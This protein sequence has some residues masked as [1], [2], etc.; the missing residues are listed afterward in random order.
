MSSKTRKK[1]QNII[2]EYG[3]S[4]P[5]FG[6][7]IPAQ[8][9]TMQ[10]KIGE[11]RKKGERI[12]PYSQLEKANATLETPLS[13]EELELFL[14]FQHNCGFLLYFKDSRLNHFVV[15]DPK[16]IIDATKCIVTSERFAVDTWSKDKW[17]EMVT[18]GKVDETYILQIWENNSKDPF[19]E[20][21]HYLLLVLQRLD[22]IAKP[23]VYDEGDDVPVG[24]Y[25]AP[26]ML[27]STVKG[28]DRRLEEEDITISFNFKDL[29]P[30]AV[31]HKVFAS[32]LGLWPVEAEC[33]YDGWVVLGSG[34][35]HLLLL[36][37]E[38]SSIVVSIGHRKS[39]TKIDVNRVRS[40]KHFLVQTIQRIVSLYG[41][42]LR[43]DHETV[44]RIEY[45]R[46]AI[47]QGVG[48]DEKVR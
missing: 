17:I 20:H 13:P 6:E 1:I 2:I 12:I 45:N 31:F 42:Q 21:R 46:S 29:L 34:P 44:Y 43:E 25:Y 33:L 10:E 32:C 30:P 39:P 27:Q 7:N 9:K 15:L 8:Y 47:S 18:T 3:E 16:L 40:I 35:N 26:C 11:M 28:T 4:Y 14:Q 5:D 41:V 36:R 22:I 24:F 19:F 38:S 37:R 23:K 48:V